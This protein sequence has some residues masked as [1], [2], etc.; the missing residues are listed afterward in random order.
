MEGNPVN[1]NS[2]KGLVV[3]VIFLT[4]LVI[5]LGGFIVYDKVCKCS[6][7][8]KCGFFF[9]RVVCQRK[10]TEKDIQEI[11]AE[12]KTKGKVKLKKK[13]GS[14]FEAQLILGED[15]NFKMNFK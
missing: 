3:L 6:E 12:G 14:K 5:G 13:D 10:L 2:N 8:D 7:K 1:N 11:L 15:G 4:I 9:W